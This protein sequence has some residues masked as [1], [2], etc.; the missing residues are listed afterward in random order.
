MNATKSQ[1]IISLS[2]LAQ[3][4]LCPALLC[5]SCSELSHLQAGRESGSQYLHNPSIEDEEEALAQ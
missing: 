4:S 1:F 2:P 3:S 5:G